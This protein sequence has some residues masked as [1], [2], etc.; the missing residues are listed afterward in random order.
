MKV[1]SL[2]SGIGGLDLGLERAGM[3][4]IWQAEN[5]PAA[6]N[7]LSRRWLA[8]APDFGT[9][10]RM[11]LLQSLPV[12]FSSKTSLAFYPLATVPAALMPDANAAT[13]ERTWRSS[14]GS[15]PNS[16]MGGPTGCLT[17]STSESPKDAAGCSLSDVLETQPVPQKYF[18]SPKAA[19]GILRRAERR[20]RKL[21]GALEE[22]LMGL[23]AAQKTIPGP[24][25]L[26]LVQLCLTPPR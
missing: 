18:L 14:S 10:S 16:G 24:A 26:L 7:V 20:G 1:G 3:E 6:T 13:P 4:V 11:Q 22:A 21:P 23:A 12:G 5:D 2:F 17:L 25:Q 8:T 15:W 9:P 19:T